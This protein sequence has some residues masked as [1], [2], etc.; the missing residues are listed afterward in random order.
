MTSAINTY[1]KRNDLGT[2]LLLPV[3][4]IGISIAGML[5]PKVYSNNALSKTYLPNAVHQEFG[6]STGIKNINLEYNSIAV[7][8]CSNEVTTMGDEKMSENLKRLDAF[9]K[10]ETN[11]NG[12]GAAPIPMNVIAKMKGL[13]LTLAHQPD[14][15]PTACDSIQFEYE[16][17]DGSYLEFELFEDKLQV[18]SMDSKGT[19]NTSY[20]NFDAQEINKVVN[21]FYGC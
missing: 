10:F 6:N 7:C 19:E 13:V 21:N 18:F 20:V 2:S 17:D 8:S 4:V 9:S 12:H 14:I 15:F 11:W 3:A 5:G 1:T 16:K